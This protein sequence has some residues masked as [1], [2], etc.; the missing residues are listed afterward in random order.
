MGFNHI[1]K[2]LGR[3]A[4]SFL[5]YCSFTILPIEFCGDPFIQPFQLK[6]LLRAEPTTLAQRDSEKECFGV[7]APHKQL[8]KT[9]QFCSFD[10]CKTGAHKV[11]TSL[12]SCATVKSNMTNLALVNLCIVWIVAFEIATSESKTETCLRITEVFKKCKSPNPF[13]YRDQKSLCCDFERFLSCKD[14]LGPLCKDSL[15][16]LFIEPLE[17]TV[18]M[19][20]D[21]VKKKC[22]NL[23][24]S[25]YIMPPTEEPIGLLEAIKGLEEQQNNRTI[26]PVVTP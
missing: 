8:F 4:I 3:G 5:L 20:K 2:F 23:D 25:T 16:Q 6:T 24:C 21:T 15:Y 1:I 12:T 7:P 14:M 18:N 26:A 19:V 22:Q 17:N 13:A 11:L 10:R 9:S